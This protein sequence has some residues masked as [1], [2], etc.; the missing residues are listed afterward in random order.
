MK[1]AFYSFHF[2]GAKYCPQKLD[3][4]NLLHTISE[5]RKRIALLSKN[6]SLAN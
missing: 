1:K 2:L 3:Q 6:K 4:K 5:I